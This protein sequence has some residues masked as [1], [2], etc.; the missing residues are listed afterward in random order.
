MVSQFKK[1]ETDKPREA[2]H[3]CAAQN[4]RMPGTVSDNLVGGGNWY[5]SFH[6]FG[7]RRA[8]DGR[9]EL[10]MLRNRKLRELEN[11][12]DEEIGHD[13]PADIRV[14]WWRAKYRA[15]L[16]R[17]A[18]RATGG[19]GV[20]AEKRQAISGVPAERKSDI[21]ESGPDYSDVPF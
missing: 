7:E 5:C 8:S 2:D 19:V 17:V 1:P 18:S 6:R 16:G 4:C 20:G 11:E 13:A 9:I 3:Y 14:A 12:A 21:R 10:T 15:L